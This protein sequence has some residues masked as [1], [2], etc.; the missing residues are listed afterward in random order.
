MQSIQK[1]HVNEL[2]SIGNGK[3]IQATIVGKLDMSMEQARC[4][5]KF[6]LKNVHYIPGFYMK[7]LSLMMAIMKGCTISNDKMAIIV[8][9]GL[10]QLEFTRVLTTRMVSFVPSIWTSK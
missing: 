10:F 2:I 5:V 1:R 9:K 4:Q 8:K 7:T 3:I 6:T